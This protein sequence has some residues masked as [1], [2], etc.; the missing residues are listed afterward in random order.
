MNIF[1]ADNM[2]TAA[3]ADIQA[4]L[5]TLFAFA[6][7]TLLCL[8][9]E[10]G[11]YPAISDLLAKC[12]RGVRRIRARRPGDADRYYGEGSLA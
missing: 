11:A 8:A 1:H 10:R 7:I 12:A 3:P 6:A 2:L 9:V 4:A 5:A